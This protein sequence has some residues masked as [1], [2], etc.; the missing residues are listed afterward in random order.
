MPNTNYRIAM[1]GAT[2]FVGSHLSGL[3][4]ERRMEIV[5]LGRRNFKMVPED[6]AKC[7]KGADIVINLAGAPVIE[8]WNKDYKK[9]MYESRIGCTK[10]L[11]D[12][13]RLM[14]KKPAL[15][16]SAS[17]VGYYST[18]GSQT[19]EEYTKADDFLGHMA[20]DWEQEALKAGELGIRTII[21]RIGIVLGKDG[22]AIKQMLSPFK[23]GLGGTIGNGSQAF[24]W[25][26][27][28]D[29]MHAFET[30]IEDPS[31][32]GTYNLTAPNPTTNKGITS[33]MGRALHRPTLL[34]IPEF[35]LRL[36]FGEGA[37]TLTKGQ[38]V[39]PK[40]LLESGF[41]FTFTD[42]DEAIKDCIAK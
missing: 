36:R 5:P 6:L 23:A 33:A 35:I 11:V 21:F 10:K 25:I 12:A 4:S 29:L 13:C 20:D 39:I 37:Q 26:H 1:S 38:H 15:F 32:K 14:E 28:K 17:A 7:M 40:R 19:E 16:I 30:V 9:V 31:Y 41:T 24:S 22:G 3:F 2:G 27:M 18:T 8:R 34:A 42:I